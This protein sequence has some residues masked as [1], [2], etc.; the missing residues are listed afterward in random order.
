MESYP[1]LEDARRKLEGTSTATFATH[2]GGYPISSEPKQVGH[3][4]EITSSPGRLQWSMLS[5]VVQPFPL[6]LYVL[7]VSSR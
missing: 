3:L 4:I 2:T 5:V 6:P 7:Q 1:E